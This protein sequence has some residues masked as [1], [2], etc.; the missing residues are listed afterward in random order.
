[1]FSLGL[2]TIDLAK[3]ETREKF[4][5]YVHYFM[6]HCLQ[7]TLSDL[8]R[9]SDRGMRQAL[10]FMFDPDHAQSAKKRRKEKAE[11]RKERELAQ[12]QERVLKERERLGRLQ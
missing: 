5:K 1:M 11:R 2:A 8:Q 6:R 10:D 3:A 4:R 9:G 12:Q 7:M